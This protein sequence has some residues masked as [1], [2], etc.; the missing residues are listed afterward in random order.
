[1]HSEGRL[2]ARSSVGD[3]LC[4]LATCHARKVAA[5]QFRLSPDR[6]VFSSPRLRMLWRHSSRPVRSRLKPPRFILPCQPALAQ[7]AVWA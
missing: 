5:A 2:A 4:G 7:A 3:G 6:D 1:M